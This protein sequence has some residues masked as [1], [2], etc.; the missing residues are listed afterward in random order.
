MASLSTSPSFLSS[1]SS[2]SCLS[3]S[4]PSPLSSSSSSS[5]LSSSSSSTCSSSSTRLSPTLSSSPSFP[6]NS[7]YYHL[8]SFPASSCLISVSLPLTATRTYV[9]LHPTACG[10]LQITPTRLSFLSLSCVSLTS[11]RCTLMS[12]KRGC[13]RSGTYSNTPRESG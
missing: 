1:S 13:G 4:P 11:P 7:S 6:S 12:N 10:Y 2:S 9:R 5:S 8:S 3:S